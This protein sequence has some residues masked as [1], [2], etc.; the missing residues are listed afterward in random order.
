VIINEL[1]KG[2]LPGDVKKVMEQHDMPLNE[3]KDEVEN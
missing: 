1:Q 2:I 3:T